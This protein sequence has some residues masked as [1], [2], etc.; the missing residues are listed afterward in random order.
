MVAKSGGVNAA[1]KHLHIS[2]PSLSNQIK[3]LEKE[4]NVT[5]FKKQGRNNIITPEGD[6][7]FGYCRRMFDISEE[8]TEHLAK[9]Q[10]TSSLRINLGISDD[11]DRSFVIDIVSSFL[12]K[13][14]QTRRPIIKV[15]SGPHDYLVER[16]RFREIDA[17]ISQKTL[18]DTDILNIEKSEIPVVLIAP[19]R[20]KT[21]IKASP[22]NKST[23]IQNYIG[24]TKTDWVL[25]SNK[26]LLR[27]EI[28]SYF[29]KNKVIRNIAFESDVL[30]SLV[31]AVSDEVGFA[32]FPKL[33]IKHDLKNKTI[34]LIGP[35]NGFWKNNIWLACHK[36]CKEDEI[37]L[38]LANSF[39]NVCSI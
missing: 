39:K 24:S 27:T 12:K 22:H 13:H 11:L 31:R 23:P 5:L 26:F 20:W 1:A 2:Q 17:A 14:E 16:L 32:F 8:L 25:P 18:L 6:I 3:V 35:K 15:I 36:Q 10:P 30:A 34:R 29:E 28:D 7:I 19:Y 4:L 37:L 38:S 33:Y 21:R 9:K